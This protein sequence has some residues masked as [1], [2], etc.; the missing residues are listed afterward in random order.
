MSDPSSRKPN[1]D[2]VGNSHGE[3]LLQEAAVPQQARPQLHANDAEDEEDEETE[4]EHI[5]QHGQRVEQQVHQDPHAWERNGRGG[6]IREDKRTGRK[7]EG[8]LESPAPAGIT[9]GPHSPISAP[10]LTKSGKWL[11]ALTH[12]HEILGE[13]A[14]IYGALFQTSALVGMCTRAH[15]ACLEHIESLFRLPFCLHS[16]R[17]RLA[18]VSLF[19]TGGSK[20]R[21][22]TLR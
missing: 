11:W 20:N 14:D 21:L 5:P 9:R 8:W 17:L 3:V 18:I 7:A 10:A 22:E 13:T 6:G 4:K 16:H 12:F 2:R 19:H 1:S 15:L